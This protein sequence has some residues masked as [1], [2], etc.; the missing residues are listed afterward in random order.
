MFS[1]HL[2]KPGI[3]ESEWGALIGQLGELRI[4]AEYDIEELFTESDGHSAYNRAEAFLNRILPIVADA[5]P[6][7]EPQASL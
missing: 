6:P 3:I 5:I 1:L 7:A 4:A 2:V